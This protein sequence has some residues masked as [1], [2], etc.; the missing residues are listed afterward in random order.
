MKIAI[1]H[2]DLMRRG[3][4]EQVALALHKTYPEAPIYTLCYQPHLTYPEFKDADVRTSVF[5]KIVKT[6]KWM[7]LLFYPFGFWSMR[8]LKIKGYDKV[9][10]S[11]TYASKYAS[12]D[13]A[14]KVYNYCHNPFRLAWYPESYPD[15]NESSGIKKLLYNFAISRLK[16]ID[17]KYSILPNTTIVNSTVVKKRV[18]EVYGIMN[19]SIINPPVNLKN[20][21]PLEKKSNNGSFLVV[22]RFEYY[23]RVDL[24]IDAFNELGLPL[25]IIGNGSLK[26]SL[27]N[28]SKSNITFKHDLSKK[29][30]LKEYGEARALV[31]PQEEDFG[32]TPLEANASGT[33]VIA[34][35][36]GGIT[37]TMIPF[38]DNK[39]DDITAI[40]FANQTIESLMEAIH[41]FRKN[42]NVFRKEVMVSNAKSFSLESFSEKISQ[43]LN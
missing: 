41:L 43:V 36:K 10:L 11:S 30:L 9:I 29:E 32:I 23:K 34:Y 16:K 7:K 18:E 33:P 42:E 35:G 8:L 21:K 1:V 24:V 39:K 3:G 5:Q 12:F 40:F 37:E 14:T 20:F 17:Y 31:F 19:T 4:A 6:E 13:K 26:Q 38:V 2:D 28:R 22:S 25:T 27:K 15:L